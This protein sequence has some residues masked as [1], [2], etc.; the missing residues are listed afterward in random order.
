MPI[1]HIVKRLREVNLSKKEKPMNCVFTTKQL[2]EELSR[3]TGVK[4]ITAD[5]HQ[6]YSLDAGTSGINGEGPA[7][8]LIIT[9]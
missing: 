8:I 5:P 1:R 4:M 3:R 9:L 2:V 7:V 6:K